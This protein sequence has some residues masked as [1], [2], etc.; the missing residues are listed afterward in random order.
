MRLDGAG[1]TRADPVPA[2]RFIA[3]CPA[4]WGFRLTL[5]AF[6]VSQPLWATDFTSLA[7]LQAAFRSRPIRSP[8]ASQLQA[9]GEGGLGFHPP[10]P[11]ACLG[12]RKK[13]V[14]HHQADHPGNI[15][16]L[17]HHRAVF[18]GEPS[19][20]LVQRVPSDVGRAGVCAANRRR[21]RLLRVEP[22]VR[23]AISRLSRRSLRSHLSRARGLEITAPVDSTARCLTPTSTP[24]TLG[25]PLLVGT[26]WRARPRDLN[27]LAGPALVQAGGGQFHAPVAGEPGRTG[28]GGEGPCLRGSG[29]DAHIPGGTQDPGWAGD[30]EGCSRP[31]RRRRLAAATSGRSATTSAW[32]SSATP[33]RSRAPCSRG[34]GSTWPARRWRATLSA[35]QPATACSMAATR[36]GMVCWL[37]VAA[38]RMPAARAAPAVTGPMAATRTPPGGGPP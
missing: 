11:S 2:S 19:G 18:G 7:R 33:R 27:F 34:S 30:E 29:S 9:L 35:A 14:G 28:V 32:R 23:R 13:R 25:L 22:G 17:H 31:S 21:V 16:L 20:E 26:A 24:A 6:G 4:R 8:H 10:T 5:R 1:L 36:P 37:A 12:R 38:T 3:T 15:E